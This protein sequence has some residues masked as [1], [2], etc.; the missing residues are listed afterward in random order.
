MDLFDFC[1]AELIQLESIPS[2]TVKS[3]QVTRFTCGLL[4]G[5]DV[6]FSW[7][8]N[9]NVLSTG[10]RVRI[11]H[12]I[13]TSH[14]IIRKTIVSDAGNYTCIAKNLYSESRIS[15]TLQVEGTA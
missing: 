1:S 5:E 6:S 4:T 11:S 10:E 7:T 12:D 9:G 13:D 2:K 3:G 14:L 15:T 8:R